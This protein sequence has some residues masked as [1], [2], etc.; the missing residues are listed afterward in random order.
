M[1]QL[2]GFCIATVQRRG[3][4]RE[5]YIATLDVAPGCQRRGIGRTLLRA[6][7][8][9]LMRAKIRRVRLHVSVDNLPAGQLYAA[10][11]YCREEYEAAF[12]GEGFDAW[13]L[14]KELAEDQR[15]EPTKEEP[16]AGAG[17]YNRAS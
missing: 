3:R 9:A 13:Q 5:G 6:T 7:E 8:E 17:R 11:G 2:L 10:S 12:Y 15:T 14:S 16:A 1:E 4:L